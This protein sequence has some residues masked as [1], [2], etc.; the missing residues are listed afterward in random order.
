[1][2]HRHKMQARARGGRALSGVAHPGVEVY[3]GSGSAVSKEAESNRD[4]FK[5]G[6]RKHHAGHIHG[7][8][9]KKRADKRARGGAIAGKAGKH[10][11][12]VIG[13]SSNKT[14]FSSAAVHMQDTKRVPATMDHQQ[15]KKRGG[16]VFKRGGHVKA[17]HHHGKHHSTHG[18][19]AGGRPH[20]RR[21]YDH[22]NYGAHQGAGHEEPLE[23]HMPSHHEHGGK[24]HTQGHGKRRARGGK[25]EEEEGEGDDD[26]DDSRYARGGIT[27][28]PKIHAEHVDVYQ[29][30]GGQHHW[31]DSE[32]RRGGAAKYAKG[33][34]KWISGAIKHPGAL[35]RS[36]GIPQG[37]KI[38]AK[39]LAA[40]SHSDNPTL[41]RRANLEKTLK[42]MH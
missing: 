34:G 1:M 8:H 10:D 33:G 26:E 16:G 19:D 17:G 40:A 18:A 35:H 41:R 32:R 5:R 14:P 12:K 13:Y 4:S 11:A 28:P 2:A 7:H 30:E 29:T 15:P 23:R 42:G 38:P 31:K 22:V 20:E 36:L 21:E 37:Q 25:C 9:A 39:K 24:M 6:G 27:G 3:Q